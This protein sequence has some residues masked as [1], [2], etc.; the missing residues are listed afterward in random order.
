M[1]RSLEVLMLAGALHPP[2]LRQQ[3]GI[4]VVCLPLGVRG[5][6]LTA[7]LEALAE[8]LDAP[9]VQIAVNSEED[10][11]AIRTVID[12]KGVHGSTRV[13]AEP[14]SW[15]GTGGLV[16][17]LCRDDPDRGIVVVEAHCL[18][19]ASLGD[20][21]QSLGGGTQGV[22]A[23]TDDDE[24]AGLYVFD[25]T[26][27]KPIPAIGY[28]DLKEQLLPALNR[29]GCQIRA[30]RV[31]DRVFRIRDR[32]SYLQAIRAI[33]ERHGEASGLWRSPEANIAPS[34]RI[35]G[36]CIVEPQVVVKEGAVVHDSVLLSGA[37]VEEKAV[38]SRSV[39]APGV[40]VPAGSTVIDRV[41]SDRGSA[42]L[43]GLAGGGSPP[44]AH[45][46]PRTLA[47]ATRSM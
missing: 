28:F 29:R 44:P 5:N 24:P 13:V 2:P 4:P 33:A 16:R 11:Q 39:V 17:D 38:V 6:L 20:L 47:D 25:Q 18:P 45:L 19:P 23:T 41:A 1:K 35:A 9:I 31:T 36:H 7:W 21:V 37:I 22:V 40:R 43:A 3:L 12:E 15:R 27:L 10:A 34:A 26:A 42:A 30:V 46:D 8:A 32:A 14:A